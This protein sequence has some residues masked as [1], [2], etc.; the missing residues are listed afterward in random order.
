MYLISGVG[1]VCANTAVAYCWLIIGIL[2]NA[3]C[4]L[5]IYTVE[6]LIGHSDG[7]HASC[8]EQFKLFGF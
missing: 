3:G 5:L 7:Y 6:Y 2:L 4:L 1:N 8:I